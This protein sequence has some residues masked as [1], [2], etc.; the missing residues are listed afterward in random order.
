MADNDYN[1]IKPVDGLH[2]IPGITAAKER[3]RRK[4][5]QN[6]HGKQEENAKQQPND[7]AD[8]QK[9]GQERSEVENVRHPIDY[10]A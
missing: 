6:S 4:R 5:R 3:E 8:Q 10:C 2:N 7:L 1:V 9:R